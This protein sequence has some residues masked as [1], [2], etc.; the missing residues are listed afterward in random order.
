MYKLFLIQVFLTLAITSVGNATN[1]DS[2]AVK[3]LE[4]KMEQMDNQ[5]REIR[6]DE[7]NYRIEKDLLKETYSNNYERI[8][9]IITII[10]GIIGVLGYLGIKDINSIKKE[11]TTELAKL[12]Q[13]Q[14]DISSKFTEF[15]TSKEKYDTEIRDVL[16]TN[17]EQNKKIKVLELKDKIHNLIKDELYGSA[18]EFCIVALELA[19]ND[20]IVLYSKALVH[21]RL[22]NY[23]ESIATLLRIL[24]IDKDNQSATLDLTE[25]YLMSKQDKEYSEMLSKYSTLLKEKLNGKLLELF[26]IV[27]MY[28]NKEHDKLKELS[29]ANIDITDLTSKQ[30]RIEGWQLKDLLIYLSMEPPTTEKTIVQSLLWYLD[31]QLTAVDFFTRTGIPIPKPPAG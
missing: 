16:K 24:E 30:K 6:R 18:L 10:L 4:V 25:V 29:I 15:Q 9:L 13:L 28:Q 21:T 12:K 26:T 27:K 17:D 11:Y 23:K 5:I 19:P 8:S 2:I 20:V 3:N 7:L 31:G 22:R 1:F 14:I